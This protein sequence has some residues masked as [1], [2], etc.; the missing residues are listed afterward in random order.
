VTNTVHPFFRK[1]I[2]NSRFSYG[3]H[4]VSDRYERAGNGFQYCG[5]ETRFWWH[6]LRRNANNTNTNVLLGQGTMALCT[7]LSSSTFDVLICLGV[8][9]FV[10]AM[11]FHKLD[12]SA[13]VDVHSRSLD[14][15]AI[16]VMI[17]TI[18]FM[19]LMCV[20]KFVLTKR[21]RPNFINVAIYFRC[22][23]YRYTRH[24]VRHFIRFQF[25]AIIVITFFSSPEV[26]SFFY[27]Y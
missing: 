11:W 19:L 5:C 3:P 4:V 21:V 10:K 23:Y 18:G 24:V 27:G 22:Y 16:A 12:S 9:W 14:D 1:R 20:K 6:G 26:S 25:I 13:S 8:P 7:A 2:F 17:S 15:S